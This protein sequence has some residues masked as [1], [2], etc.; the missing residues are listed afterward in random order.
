MPIVLL[1]PRCDSCMLC[2]EFVSTL[3]DRM[4][5]NRVCTFLVSQ[6][7]ENPMVSINLEN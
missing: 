1:P 7:P 3:N 4:A 5:I 2:V 6:T